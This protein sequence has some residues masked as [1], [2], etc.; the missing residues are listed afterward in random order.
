VP[1]ADGVLI[2][3][4]LIRGFAIL[5]MG[6]ALIGV[7]WS[8]TYH[9]TRTIRA[10]WSALH[11]GPVGR[12]LGHLREDLLVWQLRRRAMC[13]NK[14]GMR[15]LL[16]W[17]AFRHLARSWAR[18]KESA[19]QVWVLDPDDE[20][21][22]VLCQREPR[23]LHD[24]AL[25][26]A[27]VSA[28]LGD[29]QWA[30]LSAFAKRDDQLLAD[31]AMRACFWFLAGQRDQWRAADPDASLLAT[32]YADADRE[33]RGALRQALADEGEL[34]TLRRLVITDGDPSSRANKRDNEFYMSAAEK[35]YLIRRFERR[36]DWAGLWR[37]AQ[38][39]PLLTAV[40]M[41]QA[42]DRRWQPDSQHEREVFVLLSSA[43]ADA[44]RAALHAQY[45]WSIVRRLVCA[46][47]ASW[48]REDL[49]CA[50]GTD[51]YLR[52]R[53]AAQALYDLLIGCLEHRFG[54]DIRIGEAG[55][56]TSGDFSI[57]TE[58]P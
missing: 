54:G 3:L 20:G 51:A 23:A 58:A 28:S 26:V 11:D 38:D 7:L 34:D 36:R 49:G 4:N 21:W 40:E 44:L 46:P 56:R 8:I 35:A 39:L 48:R 30:A 42:T 45:T 37:L 19:W 33:V 17:R 25:L 18:Y 22:A 12:S 55:A 31:P 2:I 57:S 27:A 13:R 24:R 50:I 29:N 43:D 15:W 14:R 1:D 9:T 10:L 47:Q 41:T 16:G 32:A 6:F 53:P 52:N 5:V